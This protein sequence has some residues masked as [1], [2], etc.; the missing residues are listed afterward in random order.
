MLT[1]SHNWVY[2]AGIIEFY[3]LWIRG[4]EQPDGTRNPRA[5]RIFHPAGV[6]NPRP[7]L[8][9]SEISLPIPATNYTATNLEPYTEYEF[10]IISQNPLGKVASDWAVNRTLE[11]G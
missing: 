2:F 6:Y 4:V 5:T 9:P 1:L 3:E 11:D 8:D 10:Q 7:T